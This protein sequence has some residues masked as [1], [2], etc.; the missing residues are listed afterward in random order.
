MSVRVVVRYD[1]LVAVYSGRLGARSE[2]KPPALFWPI[3]SD[4]GPPA[5]E[6][7]IYLHP[8]IYEGASVHAGDFVAEYRQ[9]GVTVNVRR[10]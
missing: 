2:E 6:P 8:G 9:A 7:G 5:E 1:E 10:Y 3:E 4:D